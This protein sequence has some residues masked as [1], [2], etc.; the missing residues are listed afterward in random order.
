MKTKPVQN[1]LQCPAL[2]KVKFIL[3]GGANASQQ[4]ML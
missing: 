1:I 4:I 3:Y 2:S